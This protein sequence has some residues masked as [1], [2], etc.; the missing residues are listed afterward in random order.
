[1]KSISLFKSISKNKNIQWP[2]LVSML[3]IHL[4]GT[5]LFAMIIL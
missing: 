5:S 2:T 1:M 4:S 3:K